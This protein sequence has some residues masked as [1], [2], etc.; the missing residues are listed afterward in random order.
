M[1]ESPFEATHDVER[2][3]GFHQDG[4]DCQFRREWCDVQDTEVLVPKPDAMVN[5]NGL[6]RSRIEFGKHKGKPWCDVPMSYLEWLAVNAHRRT[7][8]KAKKVLAALRT[9]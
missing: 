5:Y 3:N 9:N 4:P 6:L 1:N 2:W 7:A 8:T